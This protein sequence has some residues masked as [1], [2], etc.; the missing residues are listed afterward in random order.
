MTLSQSQL[1]QVLKHPFQ[2]V[3]TVDSTNDLAQTWL[4]DGAQ[5]LSVVI[6]DEQRKGRGRRGR[7]WYTPPNVALALSIIL[8]PSKKF[9]TRVSLIGCLA[10]Y[11]LCQY[12]NIATVGIKWPNDVQIEGKKVCGVLPEAVWQDDQLLGV[13]L[14]IGVN[15]RND[16]QPEIA[17]I[18]T[19]LEIAT[20]KTLNRTDLI[21]YL[22]DGVAYWYNLLEKDDLIFA[23]KARLHTLGQNVIITGNQKRIV[24]QAVDA[25]TDGALLIKTADGSIQRILAGDVSLRP[26]T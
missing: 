15:I 25:D 1:E 7:I 18:A 5:P 13:I 6:A 9:A 8:Q 26:Q 11:D 12:L 4:K 17:N 10:V 24:G 23:W 19:T 14:G 20:A 16:L 22:L 21:A 3:A 2:Y